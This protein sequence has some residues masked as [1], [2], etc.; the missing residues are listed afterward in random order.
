MNKI[1]SLLFATTTTSLAILVFII[2]IATSEHICHKWIGPW[3]TGGDVAAIFT[4]CEGR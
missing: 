4:L 3:M 2:L 1:I